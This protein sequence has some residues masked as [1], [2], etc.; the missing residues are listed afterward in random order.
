MKLDIELTCEYQRVLTAEETTQLTSEAPNQIH[1]AP[2]Q[3][4]VKTYWFEV[5][6][7]FPGVPSKA[8]Y[9]RADTLEAA[10]QHAGGNGICHRYRIGHFI[11]SSRARW[12]DASRLMA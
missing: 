3:D 1:W 2:G 5:H 4:G 6:N 10:Q 12:S 9:V 7:S 11:A 8:F